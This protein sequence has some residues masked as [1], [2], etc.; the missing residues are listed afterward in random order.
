M[1]A[2]G[3][4][5]TARRDVPFVTIVDVIMEHTEKRCVIMKKYHKL[6]I[7]LLSAI[8]L[9]NA[10]SFWTGFSS[11]YRLHIFKPISAI[12]SHFTALFSFAA[13]E[14]CMYIAVLMLALGMILGLCGAFLK[15]GHPFRRILKKYYRVEIIV[16]LCTLLVY[17]FMWSVPLRAAKISFENS[18]ETYTLNELKT[19][20]NY[21][22]D[23]MEEC[24]KAVPRNDNREII[25]DTDLA[26]ETRAAVNK[27]SNEFP[28]LSGFQPPIKKAMCSDFLDW[29]GIAG[30]TYPFSME[31]TYNKY[32]TRFEFPVLYSHELAHHNGYYRENEAEFLGILAMI[33]SDN[34]ILRYS[35]YYTAYYWIDRAFCESLTSNYSLEEATGIY[36][37]Q[38]QPSKLL[39]DDELRNL[40][41][42]EE[43]YKDEVNQALADSVK[44]YAEDVAETGW[45]VQANFMGEAYYD[46]VVKLLLDYYAEIFSKGQS[47]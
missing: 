46:G 40:Q 44:S 42:Y 21:I 27:L 37:K 10:I 36:M 7:V 33:Q 38:P 1:R 19:L 28:L 5:I 4:I 35:G 3:C 30:Y 2:C 41:E 18:K 11:F 15:K 32:I 47:I 8:V 6:V 17:T 14:I 20:R 9:F 34:A 23:Q 43:K 39:C 13:G 31:M 26:T 25:Y 45:D 24:A 29:M 12:V 16:A 22:L